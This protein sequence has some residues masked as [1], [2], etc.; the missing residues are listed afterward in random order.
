MANF[1]LTLMSTALSLLLMTTQA[2][3]VA[4]GSKGIKGNKLN[5]KSVSLASIKKLDVNTATL[6]QLVAIKG[7]GPA[8]AKAILQ[9]IQLNGALVSLDELLE[10]RGIGEKLLAKLKLE[11]KIE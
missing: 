11:L 7:I 6:E 5:A 1:K 2:E 8:K 9:Y 10:I 3:A 4:S